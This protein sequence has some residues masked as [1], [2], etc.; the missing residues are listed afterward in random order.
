[1][2]VGSSVCVDD[3]GLRYYYLQGEQYGCYSFYPISLF[4][5]LDL[6]F[7]KQID[8][9]RYNVRYGNGGITATP[10]EFSVIRAIYTFNVS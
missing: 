5:F 10:F 6:C 1:M 8:Y 7:I 4:D 3:N 9:I 2:H